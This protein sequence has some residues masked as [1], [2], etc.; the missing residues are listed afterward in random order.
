MSAVTSIQRLSEAEFLQFERRA[1][2]KSEFFDGEMFAMAGGTRAHS[3]IATNLA[4]KL[5]NRLKTRS[6]VT[7]NADLRVKVEATGLLTYPDISVVC[8]PQRFLDAEEDT[9]LNPTLLAEVLSDS[10]EAY[11]RGRKFAHYRRIPSLRHYVLVSQKEPR[12]ELLTQAGSDEWR[13]REV[14][15][16]DGL[17]PLPALEIELSLS[18]VFF[19]VVFSSSSTRLRS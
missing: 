9:L 12:I 5:G 19:Q 8:G 7:Y 18:E 15:G 17:L 14:T 1:E 11:D 16:L 6:C 13:W 3:L 4:R 2:F 10:T